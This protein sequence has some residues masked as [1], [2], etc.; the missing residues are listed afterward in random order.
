MSQNI[1]AYGSNMCSGRLR[2]YGVSP[3]GAGRAAVLTGYQL[4]FNKRSSSDDSGKANV[5]P[6]AGSEV[7]G[8]LYTISDADLQRLDEGEVGYHRVPLRIQ[9]PTG[10]DVEAWVYV[11][12]APDR[13]PA[14]RPYTWYQRFLVEG[15]REHSLPADY[16]VALEGIDAVQDRHPRRDQQNRA[17]ECRASAADPPASHKE[18]TE[19]S[20][21]LKQEMAL[22]LYVPR[23][24]SAATLEGGADPDLG[25]QWRGVLREGEP[26]LPELL[27][28]PRVVILGEPGAGKS[29]VV[30]A[31]VLELLSKGQQV[32][33]FSEL[34]AY[35][36][37]LQKLLESSTP[38][39][40]LDPASTADGKP[41]QRTYVLDGVD[42]I[43]REFLDQFGKDLTALLSRDTSAGAVL[44][45]RQ[46]FYV[47][48][49]ALLPQFP[50]VF[51]ILDFSDDDIREFLE[52]KRIAPD[53]FLE[54]VALADA[55]EEIRNP[56]V[57][58]VTTERFAQSGTLSKLR[59]DNL[60]YII[61]RLIHTRPLINPQR[62][63]RA[64]SMLA[65]AAETCSRNE[66]TEPEALR[67]IQQAMRITDEGA[68]QMLNE[69]Q[70]SIL[71]RT[72]NG[73]A[74][75]MR[76][77]G[78]YLA[79]EALIDA[80]VD[81]LRELAFLDYDTP[82]ESWTNSISYLAEMNPNVRAFFVRKYPFWM[83]NSSPAAFSDA[84]KAEIVRTIFQT[85]ARE[86]QYI[87]RHPRIT[88][89]RMARF[90]PPAG[91]AELRA[92]LASPTQLVRGNALVLLSLRG[93]PDTVP[94]A[95]AILKDRTLDVGFRQCAVL[96]VMRA[97][98][99]ALV[100]ELIAFLDQTDP[101]YNEIL[102]ATGALSEESQIAIVL[103]L[104]LA[105]GSILNSAFYH[106]REFR[107]RDAVLAT[108]SYFAARPD[109]L[110]SVR[111]EGY[112][113]PLLKLLTNYWDG[114][115]AERCVAIIR[116]INEQ[117]I[118]PD[119]SGIAYKL[120]RA[121]R[122]ADTRGLVA[123]R[124]LG[125]LLAQGVIERHRW[126]YVD[127]IIADLM[128][129]E[130]GQWLIENQ[131]TELIKQF[132]PYLHGTIRDLL[133][134]FSDGL[135][136][137][138]E[139]N[140]RSYAAE[141]TAKE[142]ARNQQ[143]ALL[144]D[145][146][147]TGRE[148]LKTLNDFHQL[149]ESHWPELTSDHKD[150]LAG[151]ASRF[152][153]RLDLEHSVVWQGD[154]LTLPAALPLLLKLIHRY[155]LK[156]D[157]DTPLIYATASWDEKVVADYSRRVGLSSAARSLVEAM[158]A[159][160]QSPRALGGIIG[161][162]RDSGFW[163]DSIQC[164]LTH[165]VLD[166]LEMYC[167]I[168]AL[169]LLVQHGAESTFL[170]EAIAKA[171]SAD[172]RET[173][174]RFLVERQHRATIERA[175][176]ELLENEQSLRVGETGH[177]VDTPLAWIAKIRSEFAIPKL[178]ELR[179]RT[180]DFQL[181]RVCSLV[182]E[183]LAHIDRGQAARI[184]AAQTTR[185][186]VAWRQAQRFIAIEQERAAK[187]ERIQKTPFEIILA[188]LKGATSIQRLKVWCEGSTDV[189]V[190][191]ALLAQVPDVPEILFDFVGGWPN[192]A[193]KD[194]HSF[195]HGSKEA[196]VVMDGDQGR[197]FDRP[198]RPPT[199]LARDQAKRFVGLPVELHVL[200][201]YGI[202]NYFPQAALEAV[203]GRDLTPF[204]PIPDHVSV[205]EYLKDDGPSWWQVIKRFLISRLHL[206]MKLTG[207]SLYAKSAN[208]RVAQLLVVDRDL[209][210]TDL[211]TIIHLIAERAKALA[212]S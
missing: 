131:A 154:T 106:F 165:T 162:V 212:D 39:S 5:Q 94:S 185:A 181:P 37:D 58:S 38:A 51:H 93:L 104:L 184:I 18:S 140:A 114:A 30:R 47:T 205:R 192:L 74:F 16:I 60:S 27:K 195:E 127:Q 151:E 68:Q 128:T 10:T 171:T 89:R 124:F 139:E 207:R 163:S 15:A 138:Q 202:E 78:E 107:S 59:S 85:V 75:Q 19:Y 176:S 168:D 190:F 76:S 50:T 90:L 72:T 88:L 116:V 55:E 7:W 147:A 144:Q 95:L 150:W 159:D 81:R 196:F 143:L 100:P 42:E 179:G 142:D 97:G 61:D 211:A 33:I 40:I 178:A 210:G 79:A 4:L 36:G 126:F 53:A 64:L 105:A 11:S 170:E 186:P 23:R 99:S 113:E 9:M 14:L 152:L 29:L 141:R 34:K 48:H 197:R 153:V 91:D 62:Q 115:V 83:I 122:E 103:P 123:R 13:D 17:L 35:R 57:L 22:G 146:I 198:S 3:R 191:K 12:S 135:I 24:F 209:S 182:T 6:R 133:R 82:N 44:T 169:H 69:L 41:L 155:E 32:P 8:V 54:A 110:N 73:F 2:N 200:Q 20:E 201:R 109:D 173:A 132:S 46:A 49:R 119:R 87:Y 166:P 121:I 92:A 80:S 137:A 56:F 120:F 71:R 164:G 43:P 194:P 25:F 102:D 156:I 149:P 98:S 125:D 145:R 108:L 63:R 1:F 203:V 177:P 26:Q 66:L 96:A 204:F 84:E 134:P 77:Y 175:L 188:K 65:V 31:A 148:F 158:L 52:K 208:E 130:T 21:R 111:A 136:D 160:P 183:T 180:L 161:F 118:Y 174:F 117:K 187:I 193:A 101:L 199:K 206:K 157:P 45:A 172:L 189:P 86:D 28:H 129:I 70:A 167:Q 67:V 112:L